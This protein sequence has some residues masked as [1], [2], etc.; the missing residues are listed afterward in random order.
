MFQAATCQMGHRGITELVS[1]SGY[2][3]ASLVQ[4]W[5]RDL[6]MLRV[7]SKSELKSEMVGGL[8]HVIFSF[9][10]EYIGNHNPN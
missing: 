8:E 5:G 1:A 2:P 6:V 7:D 9:S 4:A 3:T 10:W